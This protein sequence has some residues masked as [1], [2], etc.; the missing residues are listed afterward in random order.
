MFWVPIAM[1]AASMLSKKNA[2]PGLSWDGVETIGPTQFDEGYV[3]EFEQPGILG[4]RGN[5]NG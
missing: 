1:A 4:S 5:Q 2:E 3:D